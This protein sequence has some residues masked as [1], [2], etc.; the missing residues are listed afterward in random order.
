MWPRQ[1]SI[2][3]LRKRQLTAGADHLL[4]LFVGVGMVGLNDTGLVRAMLPRIV[5]R[6]SAVGGEFLQPPEN[7]TSPPSLSFG[8]LASPK[9]ILC[10]LAAPRKAEFQNQESLFA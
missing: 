7:R 1:R 6:R 9:F 5:E 8:F 3:N 10:K 2:R 4:V